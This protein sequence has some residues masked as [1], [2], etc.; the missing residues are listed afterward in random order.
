LL[1]CHSMLLYSTQVTPSTFDDLKLVGTCL[2]PELVSNNTRVFSSCVDWCMQNLK[3]S[4][5]PIH[6]I[7]SWVWR[8]MCGRSLFCVLFWD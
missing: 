2:A 8:Q 1:D 6:H 3:H 5:T 4:W 7:G